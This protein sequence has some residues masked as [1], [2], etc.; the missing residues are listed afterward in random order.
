MHVRA[1]RDKRQGRVEAGPI[2]NSSDQPD[3]W[4]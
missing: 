1:E 2:S 4:L 3:R